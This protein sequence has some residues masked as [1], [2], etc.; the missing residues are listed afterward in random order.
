MRPMSKF[1]ASFVQMVSRLRLGRLMIA[2]LAA[3]LLLTGALNIRSII[4]DGKD[5]TW[6][7][8]PA[9]VSAPDRLVGAPTRTPSRLDGQILSLQD[10]LRDDPDNAPS[11][12]ALGQAYLQ[13]ARDTGDPSYYPKAEA[14]FAKALEIDSA[15][16][17]AMVGQGTV[18]LARHQFADALDWGERARA[19]N[20]YHAPAYGVI[21]DAQVEL[22]Q[23]PEA[24][25][26]FQ[27]MVDLRPDLAS[28]SRVSYIRELMGDR[29]GA[30]AAMEQAATA[31]AS[32]PENVA[33]TQAQL[34]NLFFEQ[35]DLNEAEHRYRSTLA[36]FPDY[37][38]GLA[39]LGRVAAARGDIDEAIASYTTAIQR[40]PAPEFVIALG[41]ILMHAGR[42]DEAAQQYELVA[43]MQDLYAANG[44]DTDLE[45][46][47][48]DADHGRD[49]TRA[50]ARA[51]EGF[52]RQPSVKAA[53]I[54]SWT[55]Y[56]NGE[57]AAALDVS[58]QALR[59]G[60]KDALMLFH[61][62]MIEARVGENAAAVD[63][64]QSALRLNP[65]FSVRYAE[66]AR[67]TLRGLGADIPAN[68]SN[69][70]YSPGN[71]Q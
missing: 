41:D 59:L 19:E 1:I 31:G 48:F 58:R 16:V 23:Y 70:A 35:G 22:G 49:L 25:A 17:P 68:P 55:L 45:M 32:S 20:P 11:A 39:G 38:Y 28:F 18:A 13:K 15:D 69:S 36:V 6:V 3:L 34:G 52:A 29:T 5:P 40:L 12:T 4:D 43:A 51:R 66:E 61:A 8:D 46:A 44:V 24:I 47:L 33:W 21:G 42:S 56:Q 7:A 71:V 64:L 26:T 54:L 37:V 30:I 62:G 65:Y 50:V 63:H 9:A 14:L 10:T 57:Y 60:T 2:T 67:V 53:D 27:G